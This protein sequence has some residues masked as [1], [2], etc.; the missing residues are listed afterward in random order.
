MKI[1]IIILLCFLLSFPT[2]Y[3]S[4]ITHIIKKKYNIPDEYIIKVLSKASVDEN[5]L[6]LIN[7]PK[8][9]LPFYKYKKLLI[10]RDK[11]IQGRN[12]IKKYKYWLRKSSK[13][14]NVD[15]RIIAAIIGIESFYGKH[16]FRFKAL[17]SL[18]T[19]ATKYKRREN[20]FTNELASFLFFCYK[21]KLN[22]TKIYSSYAGAIG[23]P[24][25]MPSNI[26]KYAVDFNKNGKTDII[27]EIPDAIGSVANYLQK[28][29]FKKGEPT[30]IKIKIKNINKINLNKTVKLYK[31]KRYIQIPYN[32]RKNY[33]VKIIKVDNS[34]W[35]TF[36]NF[37]AILKYN[38]SINYALTILILSK[39]IG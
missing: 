18:Y 9:K 19:L 31:I 35:L 15:Y 20:Y 28:A 30:A 14:Y 32:L 16:K 12:F 13:T 7:N 17:N 1:I 6:K 11:I 3:S 29:G 21:N 39:K 24:Q 8:E 37:R 23:I 36:Q 25:F 38:N 34:Y 27:K 26:L 10:N 4:N 2:V 33:V 22:T 5:V